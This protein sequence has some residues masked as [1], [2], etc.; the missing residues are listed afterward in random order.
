MGRCVSRSVGEVLT[1]SKASGIREGRLIFS[2]QDLVLS[3]ISWDERGIHGRC[4][5]DSLGISWGMIFSIYKE[6]L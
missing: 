1:A 2:L 3:L 4:F 6:K 5:M